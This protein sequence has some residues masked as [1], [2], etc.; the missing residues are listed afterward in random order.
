MTDE[1]IMINTIDKHKF[2]ISCIPVIKIEN[3]KCSNS[4]INCFSL[5][6]QY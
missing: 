4:M 2:W 5:L 6:S 3:F 1:N